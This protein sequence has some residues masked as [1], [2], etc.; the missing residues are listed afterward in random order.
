MKASIFIIYLSALKATRAACSRLNYTAEVEFLIQQGPRLTGSPAHNTVLDR[1]ERTLTN[2]GLEVKSDNYTFEYITPASTANAPSLVVGSKEVEIASVFPYS[3]YTSDLGATGQLIHVPGPDP[4]WELARGNIAIVPIT[5]P[6]LP[7]SVAFGTWDPAKRWV[8]NMTNPLIPTDMIG[9]TLPGA[10][11]AGVKAVVF[12]WDDSI[13]TGNAQKQYLPFKFPYADIPAVFT[14]GATSKDILAAAKSN[15]SATL[16]LRSEIVP[17]TPTRTIY[18]VVEGSNPKKSHDALLIVTHTDGTNVIEE[19]GHIGVLQL[20]QDV[21]TASPERTHVFVFTTG[22]LRMPAFTK[23]GKATT[24]WLNDHPEFWKGGVGQRRAIAAL[25]IEHLGAVEFQENLST[26]SY[27][28]TGRVQP[29]VLYASTKELAAITE[30]QWRGA[31]PGFTRVSKSSNMSQFGEGAALSDQEIPNIS[32][33]TGPLY[34]LAEW[35]GD[36]HDLVDLAALT[37]Q[38]KSFQRLR[39]QLDAIDI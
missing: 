35:G 32:L 19:N 30:Q 13:S 11:K 5:N 24:R 39:K 26:N 33:V 34:L 16:T 25:V 29:E 15:S 10:K 27:S 36:E 1:I 28:S 20:A 14:S 31:D 18:A 2:L 22:H 7:F 21:A 8:G 37:R 23:S 17:N 4:N 9:K 12:A 38:V 3:G 6:S